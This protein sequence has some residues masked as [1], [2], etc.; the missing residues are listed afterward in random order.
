MIKRRSQELVNGLEYIRDMLEI[1]GIP[2][3]LNGPDTAR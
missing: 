1:Y 3:F 2:L